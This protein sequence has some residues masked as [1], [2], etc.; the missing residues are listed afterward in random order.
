MVL[1]ELSSLLLLGCTTSLDLLRFEV[2][3][4]GFLG[5]VVGWRCW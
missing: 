4:Q 5:R 2:G 3:E 1:V